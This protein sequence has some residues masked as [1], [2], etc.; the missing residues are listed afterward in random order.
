MAESLLWD[1][2]LPGPGL[3]SSL[4]IGGSGPFGESRASEPGNGTPGV[5]L[6][7]SPC[8]ADRAERRCSFR[9][10]DS[11]PPLSTID[12]SAQ[13]TA[14]ALQRTDPLTGHLLCEESWI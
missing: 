13:W 7:G 3:R 6:A 4:S 12:R 8:G 5:A 11:R 1:G 2:W 9:L 14:T 10:F